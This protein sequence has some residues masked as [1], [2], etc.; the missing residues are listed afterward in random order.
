LKKDCIAVDIGEDFIKIIYGN[1][2]KIRNYELIKTPKGSIQDD[3]IIDV[4]VI[5][6]IIKQYIFDNNLKK[7][8]ILYSIH[9]QD[10]IVRHIEIP[11]MDEKNIKDS[12][13]WEVKQYLPEYGN[14]FYI[15]YEIIEKI[16]TP[17]EKVFKIM[18]AAVP[19]EKIDMLALISKD[20]DL[21]LLAVDLTANSISRVFRNIKNF[22]DHPNSGGIIEIRSNSSILMI[23]DRGKLIIEKEIPIGLYPILYE[24]SK[25]TQLELGEALD[26]V[27]N[28]FDLNNLHENNEKEVRV[29]N[30]VED[31]C[32]AFA[33]IIQFYTTG[34]VQK[35]VNKIYIT[36]SGNVIGGL[37]KFV[38]NYFD[39]PVDIVQTALPFGL[40]MEIPKD[41]DFKYFMGSVGLLL[42]KE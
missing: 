22:E 28:K 9:G 31:I 40:K 5:E 26:F 24:V 36:G 10:I 1:Q 30:R 18:V 32:E 20:L 16:N 19:K 29:Y 39:T 12:I 35:S 37:G 34:K 3:K 42:R 7:K 6:N 15:D 2:N 14:N 33:K 11:L 27:V 17:D 23:L 21:N 13:D 4:Q 8:D 38:E 25:N 41:M